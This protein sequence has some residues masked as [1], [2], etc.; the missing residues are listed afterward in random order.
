MKLGKD[1][2]KEKSLLILESE[3]KFAH[4]LA[5]QVI[6]KPKLSLWLV[7][8]IPLMVVYHIYEYQ[9]CIS[10]RKSFA[11]NYMISRK[12]AIEE[13]VTV[14][15]TGKRPDIGALVRLSDIPEASGREYAQWLAVLV[16]YYT[17]LLMSE[18][19]DFDS[20][21]RS[22]YRNRT[23]YLIFLNRLNQAE[24]VLNTSLKPNISE[25]QEVV[26]SIV[27]TMELC[28]EKLRKESAER[29]FG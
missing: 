26:E 23:N 16:E 2:V 25:T 15:R 4:A 11:E 8:I 6:E 1:I 10:G 5:V 9:K 18:G 22:A 14:I 29:I 3:E 13:A 12:R 19:K 7:L 21:V 20:L 28:S 24:K 27:C 17:D